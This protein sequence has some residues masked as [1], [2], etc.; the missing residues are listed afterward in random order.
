MNGD[1]TSLL[2][3]VFGTDV[4]AVTEAVFEAI[5]N[6]PVDV[7]ADVNDHGDGT[8]EVWLNTN[9]TEKEKD[10]VEVLYRIKEVGIYGDPE[11]AGTP[12]GSR[13]DGKVYLHLAVRE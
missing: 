9:L 6:A 10:D 11:L 3:R 7:V 13:L 5:I 8:V 2:S 1:Q 4:A 12:E